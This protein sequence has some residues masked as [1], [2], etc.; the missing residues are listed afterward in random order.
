M[1]LEPRVIW[2]C[3]S[4]GLWSCRRLPCPP[5][6]LSSCLLK[7]ALVPILVRTPL[8][9]LEGVR[10]GHA[11]GQLRA[12]LQRV[13]QRR[14]WLR[15]PWRRGRLKGGRCVCV[16]LMLTYDSIQHST[17]KQL[18]ADEK[19]VNYSGSEW[20]MWSGGAPGCRLPGAGERLSWLDTPSV[21]LLLENLWSLP[22]LLVS[23]ARGSYAPII[24][25]P[26]L[27]AGTHPRQELVAGCIHCCI[28][29]AGAMRGEMCSPWVRFE[30]GW[31][32]AVHSLLGRGVGLGLRNGRCK[33]VLAEQVH[34][35]VK[36]RR[37]SKCSLCSSCNLTRHGGRCCLV[38][39][40]A[41]LLSRVRL[42]ATP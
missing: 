8:G 12:S 42:F 21:G 25:T 39:S 28:P 36:C 32:A 31:G 26:E 20:I 23:L 14:D 15:H 17:V 22:V 16:W 10:R 2:S 4:L 41:Q 11:V 27:S 3:E 29:R 30:A 13:R 40:S 1:A 38:F 7:E 37:W 6:G 9:R 35:P 34:E 33:A 5:G 24:A 18:P 19:K